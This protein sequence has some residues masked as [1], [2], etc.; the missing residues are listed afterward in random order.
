VNNDPK[1]RTGLPQE[2]GRFDGAAWCVA[3]TPRDRR[4]SGRVDCVVGR[5]GGERV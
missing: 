3:A 5:A 2:K 1:S 4:E